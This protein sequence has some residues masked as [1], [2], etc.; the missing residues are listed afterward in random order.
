MD[1][2]HSVC[3]QL[4]K[5]S[6]GNGHNPPPRG[7]TAPSRGVKAPQHPPPQPARPAKPA[8]PSLRQLAEGAASRGEVFF[9]APGGA[10]ELGG[11][12]V[13]LYNQVSI[14][15]NFMFGLHRDQQV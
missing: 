5:A 9:V 11:E 15:S 12:V 4:A 10:A 6:G 14:L 1:T 13:V 3:L 7:V 8:G 2:E